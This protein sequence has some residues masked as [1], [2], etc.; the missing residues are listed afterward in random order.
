MSMIRRLHPDFHIPAESTNVGAEF[1]GDEFADSLAS[2]GMDSVVIFAK[3]HYGHAY[4]KT[5]VGRRHPGL[6][7]SDLFGEAVEACRQRGIEV[8]AYYSALVDG[9]AGEDDEWRQRDAQGNMIAWTPRFLQV[10]P[11]TSYT[12]DYLLPQMR[13]V[14]RNYPITGWHVDAI[15][16]GGCWC[17]SCKEIMKEEGVNSDIPEEMAEFRRRTVYRFLQKMTEA[18]RG[19]R[20]GLVLSYNGL[21]K[22][23]CRPQVNWSDVVDVEVSL[24]S[25]NRAALFSRHIRT[26][27]REFALTTSCRARGVA[28]YGSLATAEE[29]RYAAGLALALGGYCQFI[30][31]MLPEGKLEPPL[32]MRVKEAYDFIKERERW[33]VGAQPVRY[34]VVMGATEPG[35]SKEAPSAVLGVT[36]LFRECHLPFDII[37]EEEDLSPYK[38]LVLPE[39]NIIDKDALRRVREYV[40]NGGVLF[41]TGSST[42]KD[43]K[44]GLSDVFGVTYQGESD[45]ISYLRLGASV[46]ANLPDMVRLVRGKWLRVKPTEEADRLAEIVRPRLADSGLKIGHGK[47]PERKDSGW[48]GILSNS[49]GSGWVLYSPAPLFSDYAQSPDEEQRRF[50]N[51]LVDL[52]APPSERPVE[53]P[54]LA[55]SAETSLMKL[56]GMWVLHIIRGGAV[57]PPELRDLDVTL[58]PDFKPSRV[59]RAP[60]EQ[61]L[62]FQMDTSG[63]K[64]IIPRVGSH[65]ILVLEP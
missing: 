63:V 29:L 53:I 12:E 48:P 40:Q 52:A 62:P 41:A 31:E 1:D 8:L 64:V 3:C 49:F 57:A 9:V 4:W 61:E 19:E 55:P 38:L 26:V 51:N 45:D 34:A 11:N 24:A 27:G 30:S 23:G 25:L 44:F 6:G 15:S 13:E 36:R 46:S 37:D 14:T 50:M 16:F 5:T 32:M 58:R 21:L 18:V 56:E 59:Y 17:E 20:E 35:A 60:E 42:L 10:C 54:N 39:A 47:P 43:G 2:A 33:C 22:I 28:A 7:E 65:T